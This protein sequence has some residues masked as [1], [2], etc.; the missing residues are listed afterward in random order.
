MF[1]P[2]QE[3]PNLSDQQA[4]PAVPAATVTTSKKKR[5]L[6]GTPGKLYLSVYG[7]GGDE[8]DDINRGVQQFR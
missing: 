8:D 3:H 6:P 2:P 1:D 7:D 5:N 4:A